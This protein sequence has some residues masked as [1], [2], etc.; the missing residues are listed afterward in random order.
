[1]A[2]VELF[3][4]DHPMRGRL[5]VMAQALELLERARQ[6][7]LPETPEQREWVERFALMTGNGL[8]CAEG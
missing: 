3:T 5:S 1:M 8:W 4:V 6:R 2:V 7:P